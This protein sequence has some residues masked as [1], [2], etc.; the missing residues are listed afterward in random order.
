MATTSE[1]AIRKDQQDKLNQLYNKN[2]GMPDKDG[3]GG[4]NAVFG[5]QGGA[6][7]WL[8]T[9]NPQTDEDWANIDRM[10]GAS[11]EG[12]AYAASVAAGNPQIKIGGLDSNLSTHSQGQKTFADGTENPNFNSYAANFQDGG[13]L[14]GLNSA[15]KANE[16]ATAAGQDANFFQQADADI[17]SKLDT[18]ATN[19]KTG[20]QVG[21]EGYLTMDDLTKF[22]DEREAAKGADGAD[23]ADGKKAEGMDDFMKFMMLMSV[24]GGGRGG[25]GGY[26]GSQYGYGGLNP[27]GVQ[28]AYNPWDNMQQGWNFMQNAFGSGKAPSSGLVQTEG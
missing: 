18:A 4:R 2:F 22:F 13:S 27:G 28:A 12:K 21:S 19:V 20:D 6:D 9:H 5:T 24:M 8:N 25:S 14:Q 7:Y 11:A 16:I 3:K 15:N 17:I 26:G 1:A 23:G 10:L